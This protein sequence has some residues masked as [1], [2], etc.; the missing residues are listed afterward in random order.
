[1]G[2]KDEMLRA[3]A[4]LNSAGTYT[5]TAKGWYTLKVKN[6]N[7]ANPSQ[8]AFVKATYTVPIVVTGAMTGRRNAA[9]LAATQEAPAAEVSVYPKPTSAD[10]I[11]LTL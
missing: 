9:A 5:P 8:D 3:V 4:V 11:D 10:R 7:T 2:T 6:A 1:M